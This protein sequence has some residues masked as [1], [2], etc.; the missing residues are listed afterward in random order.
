RIR[1]QAATIAAEMTAAIQAGIP[2]YARPA[3][4]RYPRVVRMAV[5]A[6][7][8]HFLDL[9][10]QRDSGRP[11]W[12]ELFRAIGAGE[13]REGRS[14]D[15]LQAATRLAAVAVPATL[16]HTPLLSPD[17][18]VGLERPQP[19]LL[20][21]EPERLAQRRALTAGL[22]GVPAAVGVPVPPADA[23]SSLR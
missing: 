15:A 17:V 5:D 16:S 7:L 13:Q 10:Q 2:E 12:R 11:E 1:D 23:A 20:V 18:L 3:D 21:P 19:C 9:L 4:A 22:R 14:L 6:S 8:N